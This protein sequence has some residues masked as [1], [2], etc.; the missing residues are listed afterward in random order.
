M[1]QTQV[2]DKATSRQVGGDHYK[3]MAIEPAEYSYKNGLTSLES[4]VIKYISR[5]R[6]KGGFED[7]EKVKHCV[8]LIIQFEKEMGNDYSNSVRHGNDRTNKTTR[9]TVSKA[10][11][12]HRDLCDK[13][14]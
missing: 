14:E 13:T 2:S 9:Y 8:D 7:L 1:S 4:S 3:Q 6:V 11:T 12:D 5:W 10:A